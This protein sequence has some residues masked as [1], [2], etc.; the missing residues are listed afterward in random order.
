MA[1]VRYARSHARANEFK[2]PAI[3]FAE[4][5]DYTQKAKNEKG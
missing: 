4:H 1:I 3:T 5:V 2:L